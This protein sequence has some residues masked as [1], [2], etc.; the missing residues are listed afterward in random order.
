MNRSQCIR[1]SPTLIFGIFICR[2]IDS[3]ATNYGR[4][5]QSCYRPHHYP[6]ATETQREVSA[7]F[8]LSR[9]RSFLTNDLK[10]LPSGLIVRGGK[11]EVEEMTLDQKVHAAMRKLGLK[12][13]DDVERENVVD[14]A[15][16]EMMY[17][18]PPPPPKVVERS[19]NLGEN[20]SCDDGVCHVPPT[21]FVP[22]PP[23]CTP[24]TQF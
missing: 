4:F 3:E 14:A 20:S 2:L 13:P 23:P 12:L 24:A 19:T 15:S 16:N 10:W 22:P 11:Q 7:S 9:R 21:K 5:R 6:S 18:K 8:S 1:L 17:A